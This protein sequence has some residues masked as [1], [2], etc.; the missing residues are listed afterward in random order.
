MCYGLALVSW[1]YGL[2]PGLGGLEEVVSDLGPAG[3]ASV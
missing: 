2:P 3:Q 1:G